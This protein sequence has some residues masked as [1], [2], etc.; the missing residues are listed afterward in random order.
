[1]LHIV[2]SLENMRFITRGINE[3]RMKLFFTVEAPLNDLYEE[4]QLLEFD[5]AFIC[6]HSPYDNCHCH[7]PKRG[8][9]LE[10]SQKYNLDLM[11]TVFIGD[12]GAGRFP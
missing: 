1:M 10:A 8:M 6:P 4:F 2:T 11:K 7:K 3:R 12:V 9:H 5:D